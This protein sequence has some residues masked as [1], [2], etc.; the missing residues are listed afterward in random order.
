MVRAEPVTFYRPAWFHC[1]LPEALYPSEHHD[2]PTQVIVR[3][4]C[5]GWSHV[6]SSPTPTQ[7]CNT[8]DEQMWRA[9]L[10]ELQLAG[11]NLP[12]LAVLDLLGRL[13]LVVLVSDMVF[14]FV[15]RVSLLPTSFLVSREKF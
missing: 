2:S 4:T 11:A 8:I 6:P 12:S 14:R 1:L 5:C 15:T 13:A 7:L 9:F 10:S 3:L